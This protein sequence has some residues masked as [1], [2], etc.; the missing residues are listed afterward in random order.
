MSTDHYSIKVATL[1]ELELAIAWAAEEGWNPGL[2]DADC[3]YTVDRQGFLL[4]YLG[5][6]P[7]AS[8]SAV[9][10]GQAFGFLGFYIVKPGFRGQGYGKTIWNSAIHYLAGCNIGLDGVVEQQANYQKM[11]FK[12]AFRNIRYRCQGDVGQANLAGIVDL[13]ELPFAAVA[14]Y[15]RSFFPAPRTAFLK[16]WI[17][18]P[19]SVALGILKQG[20]LAG[21]GVLRKC[22]Q[23]YKM[24]PLYADSLDAAE[25]LF[26]AL[27]AK[28][29]PDEPVYL[30]V[31]EVNRQAIEWV[32]RQGMQPE[33]ETARMYSGPQPNLP[34]QK[35]FGITSFEIG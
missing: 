10:Y 1:Q 7:I 25:A 14:S 18:Q 8:L 16:A 32:T 26:L 19:G 27:R 23:G 2:L 33:F 35:I 11:G 3:Y 9:K 6:E 24:G 15:D 17:S 34:L 12:L 31:P 22:R 13:V 29:L 21:M 5:D 28:V 20:E 30:D 4:G